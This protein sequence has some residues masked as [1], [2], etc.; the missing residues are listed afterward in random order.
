MNRFIVIAKVKGWMLAAKNP[1]RPRDEVN[2]VDAAGRTIL[3]Y[4]QPTIFKD[5]IGFIGGAHG[6]LELWQQSLEQ[7]ILEDS[8]LDED[9]ECGEAIEALEEV[10]FYYDR[11]P[12]GAGEVRRQLIE[13]GMTKDD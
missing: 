10:L 12:R 8:D 4:P 1:G 6:L 7:R 2:M 5:H 11:E 13:I 3:A 9:L